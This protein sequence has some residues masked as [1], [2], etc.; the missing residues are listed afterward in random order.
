MVS[1]ER[2]RWP[3]QHDTSLA[4]IQASREH[5]SPFILTSTLCFSAGNSIIVLFFST[6]FVFAWK[7][8]ET[9]TAVRVCV[10]ARVL[11]LT[12]V[13]DQHVDCEYV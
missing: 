3:H 10:C 2:L 13:T 1:L 11:N 4:A 5:S 12:P 8:D 6:M 9:L 7:R